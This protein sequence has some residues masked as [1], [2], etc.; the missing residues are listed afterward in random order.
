MK[1]IKPLPSD[2]FSDDQFKTPT[3]EELMEELERLRQEVE[4]LKRL[5]KPKPN[6]PFGP[7]RLIKY[8]PI[9]PR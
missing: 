1:K 7:G 8:A 5:N 2:Q 3:N 4:K 6:R 9:K